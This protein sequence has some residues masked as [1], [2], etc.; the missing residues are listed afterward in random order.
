M[1]EGRRIGEGRGSSRWR[2]RKKGEESCFGTSKEKKGDDVVGE[3]RG[4]RVRFVD[5]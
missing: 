2:K 4:L 1:E 5:L 3:E